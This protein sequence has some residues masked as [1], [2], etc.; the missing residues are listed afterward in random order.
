[1]KKIL[2]IS[3]SLR[4]DSWNTK[5]VSALVGIAHEGGEA[6]VDIAEI[7]DLP[8]FNEDIEASRPEAPWRLKTQIEEADAIIISTPEYNRSIPGVLKNAID[9]ASRPHGLNSFKGKHVLI[10]GATPGSVGTAVAQADLTH[11]LRYL[12]A[13]VV[14]QPELY[15]GQAHTRFDESVVLHPETRELLQRGFSALLEAIK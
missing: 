11:I 13:R 6:E 8:L 9:W 14:G 1:M 12:D 2:A 4:K 3:G 10:L 5:I 15:I 7:G